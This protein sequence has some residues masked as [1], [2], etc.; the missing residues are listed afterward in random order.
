MKEENSELRELL[1]IEKCKTE[2]LELENQS[3]KIDLNSYKERSKW[4]DPIMDE[5][6]KLKDR[7]FIFDSKAEDES[8]E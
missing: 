7:L 8:I 6:N 2:E 3:L 4:I 5:N 1:W